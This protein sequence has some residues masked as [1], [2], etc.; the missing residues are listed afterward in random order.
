MEKIIA[1]ICEQLGE[2]DLLRVK[3][4]TVSA[5]LEYIPSYRQ[6]EAI[7]SVFGGEENAE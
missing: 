6:E 3:L 7:L 4:E 1:K 5:L 2:D